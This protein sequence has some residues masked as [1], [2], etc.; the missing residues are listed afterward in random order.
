MFSS[1]KWLGVGLMTLLLVAL[2]LT[3]PWS[4]AAG[5]KTAPLKFT[6]TRLPPLV[7]GDPCNANGM[8]SRGDVVGSEAM[9]DGTYHAVLWP[10]GQWQTPVDLQA[11]LWTLGY[12][13]FLIKHADDVN[14]L[15]QIAGTCNC[16]DLDGV[17]R[18]HAFFYDRTMG[19]FLV[20]PQPADSLWTWSVP[21]AINSSGNIVGSL[22][23]DGP[24]LGLSAAFV[25]S[26]GAPDVRI[27][28]VPN[29]SIDLRFAKDINDSGQIVCEGYDAAGVGHA[30]LYTPGSGGSP[31]SYVD[32]GALVAGHHT[33][34]M[35]INN[36]GEVVGWS[37]TTKWDHAISYTATGGIVDLHTMSGNVWSNAYSVNDQGQVVGWYG[38]LKMDGP[39]LYLPGTGMLDLW[40]LISNPPSGM[41][42]SGAAT[43]IINPASG[44]KFGRILYAGYVLTPNQ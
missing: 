4:V 14:G 34:P 2:A 21:R 27:L 37:G 35:G 30:V 10:A 3:I 32:I 9:S 6:M 23:N 18:D 25:W 41:V 38:T 29:G 33:N 26:P 40:Q 5:G 8:N 28:Q 16:Q 24:G 36:T 22:E 1:T 19:L 20:L 39:M 43:K 13:G 12:T 7:A 15:G 31:D 11:E 42:E 44:Y 17:H